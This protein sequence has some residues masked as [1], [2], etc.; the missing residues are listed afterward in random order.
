[1]DV[2]ALYTNIPNDEGLQALKEAL[3]KKQNQSVAGKVIVTLMSLILTL[4]YFVF[5][6]KTICKSKDVQW[7]P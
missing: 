7:G 4:N 2:K 3:D 5:K 6:D 1:M